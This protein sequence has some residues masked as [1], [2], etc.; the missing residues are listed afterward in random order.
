MTAARCE[1]ISPVSGASASVAHT[2]TGERIAFWF[3]QPPRAKGF[4][5][6]A[7]IT[8]LFV[9]RLPRRPSPAPEPLP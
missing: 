8:F 6:L 7:P 2:S 4:I 5:A 3:D 9:F 1:A